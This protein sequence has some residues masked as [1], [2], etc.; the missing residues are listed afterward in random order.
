MYYKNKKIF[1]P[2][3]KPYKL[4]NPRITIRI[5][6]MWLN[7]HRLQQ[8]KQFCSWKKINDTI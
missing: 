4:N 2:P 1:S 3:L 5:D 7:Y 6:F 8:Q